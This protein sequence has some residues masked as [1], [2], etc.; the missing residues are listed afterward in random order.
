MKVPLDR[1]LTH[2][3]IHAGRHYVQISG[4]TLTLTATAASALD[5]TF[6]TSLFTAGLE[7]GTASTLLRF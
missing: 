3:S 6:G 7:F 5:A 1:F 2:A 4:I